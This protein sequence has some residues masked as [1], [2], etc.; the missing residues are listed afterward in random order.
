MALAWEFICNLINRTE[1]G[2]EMRAVM[3]DQDKATM[4]LFV[5]SSGH[6][7]FLGPDLHF[8]CD[9]DV[10][11]IKVFLNEYALLARWY[12][13]IFTLLNGILGMPR[14]KVMMP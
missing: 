9:Y 5:D 13:H 11:T 12:R 2:I 3:D 4:A 7:I 14:Y 6:N 8:G 1:Y 10:C